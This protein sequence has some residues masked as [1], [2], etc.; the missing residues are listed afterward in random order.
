MKPTDAP[1]LIYGAGDYGQV[2][3]ESGTAAGWHVFGFLDDSAAITAPS[4]LPVMDKLPE[5][6]AS[7]GLFV[8]VEDN[9][10]R[11]GIFADLAQPGIEMVNIIHPSA[12][13]SPHAVLGQGVYV[14]PQAVVNTQAELDNGAI[15]NSGA[16]VEHH[17]LL[18]PFAHV[19]PGATL[20][21]RVQIGALT[22][23][24]A[25]ATVKAGVKIGQACVIGAG[26]VVTGDIDD[27]QT[28]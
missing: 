26:A 15:V 12:W 22:V 18:G 20:C 2:V 19:A 3:A 10:A 6:M 8:A 28:V 4:S 16:I 23:V 1:L 14:G 27:G 24:G 17:A 7:P 25:G 21:D 11:R 13:V 9:T 5:D